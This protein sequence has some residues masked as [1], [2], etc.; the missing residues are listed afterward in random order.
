MVQRTIIG[1]EEIF[2]QLKSLGV[3]DGQDL[4]VHSSLSKIGLVDNGAVAVVDALLRAVGKTG[5]LLMPAYPMK[6]TMLET[7]KEGSTFDLS[8]TPSTMGKLTEILRLKPGAMRSAHPTHSVVAFGARA[9][10]YVKSH[11]KS[12]IPFGP[13]S[14]FWKLAENGGA[15]LCLGTGIGKVTSH[16][17]IENTI[18]P[19]PLKVYLPDVYSRQ[20]LFADG[21]AVMVETFVHDPKFAAIRI[22]RNAEVESEVLSDMRKEGVVKEGMIGKAKAHLFDAV[23]LNELHR[24]R[25]AKGKTIYDTE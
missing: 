21:C 6:G 7:M 19:Y 10:T 23:A 17:V 3:L 25:L 18:D 13:Q 12:K 4:M 16:H 14:P 1:G 20:V 15:I 8:R 9:A 11:H 2:N 22:D 5:T 24:K